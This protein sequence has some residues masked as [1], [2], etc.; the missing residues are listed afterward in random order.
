MGKLGRFGCGILHIMIHCIWIK[1]LACGILYR[2]KLHYRCPKNPE[3]FVLKGIQTI[4]TVFKGWYRS[5]LIFL[6][7]FGFKTFYVW[8]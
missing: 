2:K 5:V 6:E 4:F 7:R 3:G 1:V 8:G